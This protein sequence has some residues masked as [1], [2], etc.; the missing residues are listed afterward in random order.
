MRCARQGMSKLESP[1]P[2]SRV[3]QR[4][5]SYAN[6]WHE[7]RLPPGMLKQAVYGLKLRRTGNRFRLSMRGG[8]SFMWAI[9]C[10]GMVDGSDSSEISYSVVIRRAFWYPF[11]GQALAFVAIYRDDLTIIFTTLLW[12]CG[13]SGSLLW[14]QIRFIAVRLRPS[15]DS[16]MCQLVE[17]E[18]DSVSSR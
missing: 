14:L 5:E 18:A 8:R 2:P 13:F 17:P 11:I 4:L 7:S 1:M 10:R 3:F 6:D 15:F 12:L 16:I 9:E